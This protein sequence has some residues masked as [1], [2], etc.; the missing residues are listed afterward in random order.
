MITTHQ[1]RLC[2]L[3]RLSPSSM[4]SGVQILAWMAI[5]SCLA[6]SITIFMARGYYSL[7]VHEL[8]SHPNPWNDPQPNG[9]GI[10]GVLRD[11]F[12]WHQATYRVWAPWISCLIVSVLGIVVAVSALSNRIRPLVFSVMCIL[13]AVNV[14]APS[15]LYVTSTL[16]FSLLV[17]SAIG[18]P[19]GHALIE[20]GL[21]GMTLGL[22]SCASV[23]EAQR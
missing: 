4:R 18:Q 2:G 3:P 16:S 17:A 5:V 1:F 11:E 23:A 10:I 21:C 9:N 12:D 14:V 20:C 7:E 6:S 19:A 22:L 15:V 13:A 8:L